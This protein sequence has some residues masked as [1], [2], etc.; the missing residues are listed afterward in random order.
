[1]APNRKNDASSAP[2]ARFAYHMT[3]RT[4]L[5]PEPKPRSVPYVT[6][7]HL[8]LWNY[9]STTVERKVDFSNEI[10]LW[11]ANYSRPESS[12]K[13]YFLFFLFVEC[14]QDS[15]LTPDQEQLCHLSIR[16]YGINGQLFKL[17][18]THSHQ[19]PLLILTWAFISILAS[20]NLLFLKLC[21]FQMKSLHLAA[22]FKLLE[23]KR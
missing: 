18:L 12:L 22:S 8:L 23:Q 16:P 11:P 17:Q 21:C 5:C 4:L 6:A 1:M 20:A 10:I 2:R 15:W 7:Q 9:F 14:D 3:A 13:K 19:S